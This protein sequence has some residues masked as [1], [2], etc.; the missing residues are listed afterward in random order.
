[1]T[2]SNG[3]RKPSYSIKTI[4][5]LARSPEINL[6]DENLYA[7]VYRE[8]KKESLKALDQ[9]EINKVCYALMK[10]KDQQTK[11]SR[12]DQGGNEDTVQMRKKI[13]KLTGELGWNNNP[14]RIKGFIKRMFKT[15]RLEWLTR[16]QCY[17]LIEALKEMV[18]R[19]SLKKA[20]E[21]NGN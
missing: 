7:L 3:G 18:E 11:R 10:Y 4:W 1:M 6:D 12:T 21:S 9:N 5:G 20:G 2:N 16:A 19:E 13:Y 15:E 14:T 8:T 17:K